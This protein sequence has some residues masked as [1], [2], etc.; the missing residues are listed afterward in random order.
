MAKSRK[1]ATGDLPSGGYDCDF[2]E[3]PPKSLE[4]IMCMLPFREP[5]V[6]S[7]C[8]L[9]A[10]ESCLVRLKAEKHPCPKCRQKFVTML[11]KEVQRAVLDLRVY[12]S[13]KKEG[14]EWTGE[15]RD[16]ETHTRSECGCLMTACRYNCGGRFQRRVIEKHEIEECPRCPPQ[17]K[18]V[19]MMR[20]LESK[21]ALLSAEYGE[22]L[23]KVKEEHERQI[24]ELR[25]ENAALREDGKELRKR[26]SE[27]E[28]RLQSQAAS[29]SSP[30]GKILGNQVSK[31]VIMFET[32]C[33][34]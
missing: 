21:L 8:G 9:K 3:T 5:H 7:C 1:S 27:V 34:F 22:R 31:P 12:C 23:A 26:L 28:S 17:A 10:C 24:T 32:S 13:R 16:L 18:G 19:N 2:V 14:C 6:L 20:L 15:V 11:E 25:K 33:Y 30:D 29:S 4:C